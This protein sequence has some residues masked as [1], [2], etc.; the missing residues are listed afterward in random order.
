MI[1]VGVI[2]YGYWGPNLVRNFS[3]NPNCQVVAVCDGNPD[4]LQIAQRRSPGIWVTQDA[5]ELIDHK[6][7]D[8]VVIATPANTHFELGRRA[9]TAGKQVLIEKPLTSTAT[10]SEILIEEAEKRNSVL[11]VDHTFLYTGAVRKI[12]QLLDA[13]D[14]GNV[15]YYDSVRVNL[16]LFQPDVN[17]IW[18]LAV[19]DVA[20]MDYLLPATPLA[21]SATGMTHLA[22]CAQS[23]AYM[24]CLFSNNLIA[25]IHVNWLAPAK[26]RRTLLGGDRKMVVYDDVE[27]S[28]KVKI[29]DKG[30]S[31]SNKPDVIFQKMIQYRM[32]DMYAPELDTREALGVEVAEFVRCVETGAKPLSDGASGLRV[33]RLLEAATQSIHQHGSPVEISNRSVTSDSLSRFA[34]AVSDYS[35][36]DSNG[37]GQCPELESIRTR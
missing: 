13:G 1:R 31:I 11:M 19:H 16:G 33:V 27:P 28:E 10:E 25:H 4:R 32:G 22:G 12:K 8:A 29:Y 20:I 2:G 34:S 36:R 5:R 26:I 18:D 23:I 21:V 14:L 9:L 30:V 3:D 15:L 24:T 37:I 35:Q 17:V 6:D 7:V